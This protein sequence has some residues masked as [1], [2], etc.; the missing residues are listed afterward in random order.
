MSK[1]KITAIS[2]IAMW[3]LLFEKTINLP[4]Y[5]GRDYELVD[6]GIIF[7]WRNIVAYFSFVMIILAFLFVWDIHYD[8]KGSPDTNSIKI[9]KVADKNYD[10]L[11]TLSTMVTVVSVLMINYCGI[12]ELIILGTLIFIL[13]VCY[14]KTNLFYCNPLFALLG[15]K[16][17]EVCNND[18]DT[19]LPQGSIVL[20]KGKL[21]E[22]S[23]VLTK[24]L[25]NIIFII[26]IL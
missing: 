1:I 7:S 25:T 9:G 11:S 6:I 15:Y 23:R 17:A 12:R 19:V 10:Y 26:K 8:L 14:I 20:Y 13:Y 5:F 24:K 4:I 18:N 21:T 16:I 3:L 2:F 22:D